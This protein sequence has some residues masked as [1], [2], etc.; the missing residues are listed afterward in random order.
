MDAIRPYAE[1]VLSFGGSPYWLLALLA[2]NLAF[3]AIHIL[4]EWRGSPIPLWRAFGAIEGVYIPNW[5]GFLSFT[6]GLFIVLWIVGIGGIAGWSVIGWFPLTPPQG[7]LFLGVILGA[8]VSDCLFS[9]W[10]P[11]LAGYRPN[12]GL[13][14]TLLYVAETA[15]I[16]WAF[17]QGLA[18]NPWTAV[19]GLLIGALFFLAVWGGLA[20]LRMVIRPWRRDPW[21]GGQAIPDWAKA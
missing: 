18:A 10:I 12:P 17:W 16:L 13:K 20:A 1:S 4:E 3:T 2:V 6:L 19:P 21:V 9:H 14:S 7:V 5:L 11:W 15:L 8:L